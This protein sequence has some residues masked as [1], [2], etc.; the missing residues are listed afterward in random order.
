MEIMS[1]KLLLRCKK[2]VP[3]MR[4]APFFLSMLPAERT[5]FFS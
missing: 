3:M 5:R 2:A 4:T 1:N